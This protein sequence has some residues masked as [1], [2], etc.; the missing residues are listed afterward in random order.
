M[1][2]EIILPYLNA[3]KMYGVWAMEE[4]QIDFTQD[5]KRADRCRI[6]YAAYELQKHLN[7][8]LGE[9][10]AQV[11]NIRSSDQIYLIELKL[12]AEFSEKDS[13]EMIPQKNGLRIESCS[14]VGLL[15][16]VYRFLEVQ[17]WRWYAPEGTGSMLCKEA[18]TKAPKL[19]HFE[20]LRKKISEKPDFNNI[21]GFDYDGASKDSEDLVIWMARKRLNFVMDRPLTRKLALKLGMKLY[22]GG[23]I[24]ETILNPHQLLENGKTLWE[25]HPDWYGAPET[26]KK[27]VSKAILTQFN[28]TD[29]ALYDFLVPRFLH[30]IQTEWSHAEIIY[31][32]GFDVWGSYCHAPESLKIG[33]GTDQMLY[34]ASELRRRFNDLLKNGLILH[35]FKMAL[36]LYEGCA[37]MEVP[38]NNIPENLRKSGD[39]LIFY[40]INR[41]YAKGIDDSKSKFNHFYWERLQAFQKKAQ[42][43]PIVVGEYFNLSLHEDMP[44]VM[45]KLI[46]SDLKKYHSLGVR[47]MTYMHVPPVEW[48][49]RVVTQ[50][51][52][53]ES[54]WSVDRDFQEKDFF[55]FYYP[56]QEGFSKKIYQ[57]LE[58]VTSIISDLRNF[59]PQGIWV[60]L[61]DWEGKKEGVPIYQFTEFKS[62]R[63]LF[64]Q[65][66]RDVRLLVDLYQ[67]ID[68]FIS[69]I[70]RSNEYQEIIEARFSEIN[71]SIIFMRGIIEFMGFFSKV[72]E[73]DRIGDMAQKKKAMKGLIQAKNQLLKI[74]HSIVFCGE[75]SGY[76]VLDGFS[77][78]RL[79][80]SFELLMKRE[81]L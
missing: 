80:K 10:A 50:N 34:F 21:R 31:I 70:K 77:H 16:G 75:K 8:T 19:N 33:N 32:W 5:F 43:M 67:K 49:V 81:R 25:N 36:C 7:L 39:Y 65:I 28:V 48:G 23:H 46:K 2:I 11:V 13:F 4:S 72:Y 61:R 27:E 38:K 30:K 20:V 74:T 73:Y 58:K 1:R 14:S 6:C 68:F 24:F 40:P 15:Y 37:T 71:R 78:T 63:K 45:N 17:G 9:K 3:A 59:R 76:E 18:Q 53:S 22:Q 52:Y 54:L 35:S 60:T 79:K 29:P 44:L 56:G 47:G 69:K 12:N 64:D 42:G 41:S 66:D 62:A 55:S 51:I 57:T 26:G